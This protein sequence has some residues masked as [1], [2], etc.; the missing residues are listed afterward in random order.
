M[1]IENLIDTV[2]FDSNTKNN[3]YTQKNYSKDNSN[4]FLNIFEST[5]KSFHKKT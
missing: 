2:K 5:N 1:A 3:E 4:G